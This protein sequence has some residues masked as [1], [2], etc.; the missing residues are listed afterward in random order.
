VLLFHPR[1]NAW[2]DHF[3]WSTDR[4]R[5]VGLTPVGRAT[6]ELLELNRERIVRIR[7]ADLEI[8]R[9]PPAQDNIQQ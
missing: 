8:G 2:N 7:M 4:V 6:V 5:I 9:H 3:V 1:N